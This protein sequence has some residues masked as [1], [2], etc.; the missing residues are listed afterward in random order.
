MKEIRFESRGLTI[1]GWSHGEGV[2]VLAVHGWLDNA[3]TWR[4]I[5][6]RLEGVRWVSL[7]MPGHGRS[8]HVSE[9]ETYHFTDYAPVVLDAADQLGWE[10]FHLVGHS[11]G[12]S[13]VMLVAAAY[14]ERVLSVTMVDSFGPVTSPMGVVETLRS[15]LDSRRGRRGKRHRVVASR[16]LLAE[17]MRA[18]NPFLTEPA[19]ELLLE[20]MSEARDGGWAFTYDMGVRD[21]SPMRFSEAQ[22][23]DFL[24]AITSPALLIRAAQG[25]LLRYGPRDALLARNPGLRVVDVEGNH[26]VHLNE[27]EVVAPILGEFLGVSR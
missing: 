19:L 10:R 3:N 21:L 8:G 13:V 11:M 24:E 26:H 20:R 12:G 27:P 17:R 22:V 4:P 6:E 5:A 16:E 23:G 7:D 25:A 1:A 18:G 2:P 14:P 15:A 9:G